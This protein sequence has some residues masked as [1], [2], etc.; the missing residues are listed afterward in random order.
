M[1]L[2][3]Y[4]E[5]GVTQTTPTR[6]IDIKEIYSHIR[7]GLFEL[8]IKNLYN[9]RA[10]EKK[11]KKAK[12]GLPNYTFSGQF[13]TLDTKIPIAEKLVQHSG[14]IC[15]DVDDV[16]AIDQEF[17]FDIINNEKER[18]TKYY[19]V[20]GIFISPSRT[21]LKVICSIDGDHNQAFDQ[22][23]DILKSDK[24]APQF[25]KSIEKCRDVTRR[26]FTSVD[27]DIYINYD[28]I[29]FKPIEKQPE[30]K[31]QFHSSPKKN[32]SPDIERC[33]RLANQLKEKGIDLTKDYPV[34]VEIGLALATLGED[35]RE[36]FHTVSSVYPNYD[37]EE[38][39]KKF[40][41]CIKTGYAATGK[42]KGITLG[43]FI[44]LA[45]DAVYPRGAENKDYK[46][47][48][49]TESFEELD[50]RVLKG[51]VDDKGNPDEDAC[52][53]VLW[54]GNFWYKSWK[55][56]KDGE[57]TTTFNLDY[58]AFRKFLEKAGFFKLVTKYKNKPNTFEY[59]KV[60]NN[61]VK[62]IRTEDIENYIMEWVRNYELEE[63]EN[64]LTQGSS[65]YFSD[66]TFRKLSVRAFNFK[67][68]TRTEFFS[69]FKNCFVSVTKDGVS[70]HPYTELK[71]YIWFSQIIDRE[72]HYTA[73]NEEAIF[74]QFLYLATYGRKI[75]DGDTIKVSLDNNEQNLQRV[76]AIMTGIGYSLHGYKDPTKAKS[77]N[78]FDGKITRDK[79]PEGR[80]GK[81]LTFK[82]IAQI[83]P[84]VEIDATNIKLNDNLTLSE[85]SHDTRFIYFNDA[86]E[87]FP[88]I[89]LFHMLTESMTSKRLYLD[90]I[91]IPFETSPKIG[92]NT[93]WVLKGDGG[94]FRAR[95]HNVEYTDFFTPEY[96]PR[97]HFNCQF[98]SDD[99]NQDEWN[100]FYSAMFD[101]VSLYLLKGLINFPEPNFEYRKLIA[102]TPEDFV[103][104]FESLPQNT[105][106]DKKEHYNN[107]KKEKSPDFDKLTQNTYSKW[108][109]RC[110]DYFG[111]IINRNHPE[112]RDR[113]Q[114]I[115]YITIEKK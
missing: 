72:Y 19:F 8:K 50:Y 45:N 92:V 84:T 113:V 80:S 37:P 17:A 97:D 64:K 60:E 71:E 106:I 2:I 42:E 104:H 98:F 66:H 102:S 26:C 55:I 32:T 105:R 31:K 28:A 88:F 70:T 3:S 27:P 16:I 93:N 85:V 115:D 44:K 96:S 48:F 56:K 54:K 94:S 39:D 103:E 36:I 99:W 78:I 14:F 20:H 109:T 9:L 108:L 21:G 47:S 46:T 33:S 51:K 62:S 5:N 29:P 65:R 34:W 73:D 18:F 49:I 89:R 67:R 110:A 35:G 38:T 24:I 95:Q 22:I 6:D 59:V 69:Y 15:L 58:V 30:P 76:T 111:F 77:F 86:N 4:F 68:D 23:L 53:F 12:Q 100:K 25:I 114:G 107:F 83:I 57:E 1:A 61:I 11:F 101:Y 13:K 74:N 40:D 41:H 91:V 81:S 112:G 7:S 90:P 87:A 10:D 75:F 79:K 43:T 82:A 63:L 52:K